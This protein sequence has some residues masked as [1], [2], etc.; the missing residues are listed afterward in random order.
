MDEFEK[1]LDRVL[2][3]PAEMEKLSRLAGQL[4]GG[5][6]PGAPSP[7]EGGGLPEMAG[8]AKKLGG[9]MGAGGAKSDK[10]ALL[11]ALSPYLREDRRDKLQR[12]MRLAR[13]ARVAGAALHEFGGEGSGL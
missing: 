1:T 5:D 6:A 2:S 12:A 9:L 11:K 8:L 13:A 7:R 10:A 4:F 3:D